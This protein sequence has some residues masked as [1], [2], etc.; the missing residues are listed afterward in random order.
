MATFYRK[1]STNHSIIH[2][3]WSE[4]EPG[5][6]KVARRPRLF[7]ARNGFNHCVS[8]FFFDSGRCG[9]W[10]REACSN[11]ERCPLSSICTKKVTPPTRI[12]GEVC[13]SSLIGCTSW[14]VKSFRSRIS[15]SSSPLWTP[16]EFTVRRH[17]F[18]KDSLLPAQN[19]LGAVGSLALPHSGGPTVPK[20]ECWVRGTDPSKFQ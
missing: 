4:N 11:P 15:F 2:Q 19:K 12:S 7:P 10:W 13:C 5:L 18:N 9:A 8:S 3:L 20:L 1:R 6:S 17:K 14:I 16:F